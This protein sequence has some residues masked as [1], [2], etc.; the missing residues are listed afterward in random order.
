MVNYDIENALESRRKGTRYCCP[1]CDPGIERSARMVKKDGD[2]G[3]YFV[4]Y[5]CRKGFSI[6]SLLNEL[7]VA[8]EYQ[9]QVKI[10]RK[11]LTKSNAKVDKDEINLIYASSYPVIEDAEILRKLQNWRGWSDDIIDKFGILYLPQRA[12]FNFPEKY[13]SWRAGGYINE[14]GA[15]IFSPGWFLFPYYNK[16]GKIIYIKARNFVTDAADKKYKRFKNTTGTLPFPYG[17]WLLNKSIEE[18]KSA[19]I[20][21]KKECEIEILSRFESLHEEFTP[22]TTKLNEEGYYKEIIM[23][24]DEVMASKKRLE[25]LKQKTITKIYEKKLIEREIFICEGETD[26]LSAQ[27]NGLFAVGIPGANAFR[28]SWCKY[29]QNLNVCIAFDA[30]EAGQTA[31]KEL[32]EQLNP[33]AK[34]VRK[35]VLPDDCNDYSDYFQN[36]INKK[37]EACVK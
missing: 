17:M 25:E 8:E 26:T 1:I 23:S 29:F 30:D 9:S 21:R 33:F 28:Q 35:M 18:S 13:K 31:L 34:K 3:I 2:S 22:A 4:C 14:R 15:K 37:H 24:L 16:Y 32:I 6:K 5:R 12:I 27:S 11:H 20:A 10:D 36:Y 7:G 19:Q